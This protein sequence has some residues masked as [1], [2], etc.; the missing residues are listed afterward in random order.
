MAGSD[1][2]KL[3][4]EVLEDLEKTG[5]QKK[6][7]DAQSRIDL[8]RMPG[9]VFVLLKKRFRLVIL[10]TI[11]FEAKQDYDKLKE[12]KTNLEKIVEDAYN[13][14]KDYLQTEESKVEQN[15][16]NH[17][18]K[19]GL[20]DSND[21]TDA[22]NDRM[23]ELETARNT[24]KGRGEAFLI[25]KYDTIRK[26]G[27]KILEEHLEKVF[28]KI[29]RIGGAGLKTSENQK[30]GQQIGHADALTGGTA[31]S[32]VRLLRAERLISMGNSGNQKISIGGKETSLKD[33]IQTIK[34]N[35]ELT[36]KHEAVIDGETGDFK[37]GYV[38]V[39]TYQSAWSNQIQSNKIE[40]GVIEAFIKQIKDVG[41][42][43]GSLPL[44]EQIASVTFYNLV[45][46]NPN[47]KTTGRKE[48]VEKS[49]G[50]GKAE[51]PFTRKRRVRT[52]QGTGAS[53]AALKKGK[54]TKTRK[55]SANSSMISLMALLNKK[56]P[57]AVRK[58][59]GAPG[60][61][62]VT[63]TFAN[64]IRITDISKTPK[65]FPSI[66]Y[67]YMKDPYQVFEV[68]T[69]GYPWATTARDPRKL[70]DRSI[71]EIAAGLAL[72]RFYTRR[73]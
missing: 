7:K 72:G 45:K 5:P 63:G 6:G 40:K 27:N 41:E 65:G 64:S 19:T 55:S 50:N 22:V 52:N 4:K 53:V 10:R 13:V 46:N 68:G 62:N 39:L 38:P 15:L 2:D 32:S 18:R 71:R 30:Y 20:T 8:V 49:S 57:D 66:G 21:L 67:T 3:C 23:T 42:Q 1:L 48:Q 26:S 14:Y 51:K 70:I 36:I 16:T 35:I 56:L 73:Q 60:L 25:S 12:D 59:M 17:F 24:L 43:A 44:R 69:G 11:Q 29:F 28:N 54:I 37:K 31:A 61:T 58:N 33:I 9:Q 34:G 47:I